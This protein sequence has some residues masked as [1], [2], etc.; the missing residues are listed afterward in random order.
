[1]FFVTN[2][3]GPWQ[4][5]VNRADNVGKSLMEVRDKYLNEQLLYENYMSFTHQQQLMM[6]NAASG[7]GPPFQTTSSIDPSENNYVVNDYID[8][9]FE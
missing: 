8:D 1:M 9:Y 7:G 5:F 2:H 6:S 3:P 4:N